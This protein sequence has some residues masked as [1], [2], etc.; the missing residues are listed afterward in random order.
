MPILKETGIEG[1]VTWL[2]VVPD[3][4]A[5]LASDAAERLSLTLAGPEGEDHGGRNRPS[6][7]RVSNVHPK[8]TEIHNARQVSILC[9][10]GLAEIAAA[11]GLEALDP[12]WL[13]ATMVIEGVPDL[14]YLPPSSRLRFGGPGAVTVVVDL[15]NRPCHLPAPVIAAAVGEAGR[16]FKSAAEGRRGVVGYVERA[17]GVAVGDPVEIFVPDQRAWRGA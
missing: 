11:M 5:A 17:G 8:G 12:S 13:G 14:S 10:A 4:E 6:C 1:R 2:G 3:R 16:G 9:A 15:N 7:S